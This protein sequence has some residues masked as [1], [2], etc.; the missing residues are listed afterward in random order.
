MKKIKINK[1]KVKP[2]IMWV[3]TLFLLI[4]LSAIACFSFVRPWIY[5]E[6][7]IIK[8]DD[9]TLVDNIYRMMDYAPFV[10]I[11]LVSIFIALCNTFFYAIDLENKIALTITIVITVA[12]F[13]WLT[14]YIHDFTNDTH[15]LL[16]TNSTPEIEEVFIAFSEKISTL[17]ICVFI[18]FAFIDVFSW[19][20]YNRVLR[21]NKRK[22]QPQDK[23]IELKSKYSQLQLF[24]IDVIVLFSLVLFSFV[25]TFSTNDITLNSLNNDIKIN[26][27]IH[28]SGLNGMHIVYSQLIFFILM[29]Y[30]NKE[31]SDISKDEQKDTPS[32]T[33]S[34]E[35]AESEAAVV[36]ATPE[37]TSK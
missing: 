3:Y 23:R 29:L 27:S 12:L 32:L 30:M 36:G 16:Q 22:N 17:T 8:G 37:E 15:R 26:F 6:L 35:T 20:Y 18:F 24:M 7:F 9:P 34:E 2:N 28:E 4:L 5:N 1:I 13:S 10:W 14:W 33:E 19:Y 25:S 31:L 21:E 11:N